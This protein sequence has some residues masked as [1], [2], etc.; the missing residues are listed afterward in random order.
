MQM[1]WRPDIFV[2]VSVCIMPEIQW[3]RAQNMA[4]ALKKHF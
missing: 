4:L 3:N 2:K 1:K